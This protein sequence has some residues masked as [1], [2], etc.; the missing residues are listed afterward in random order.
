MALVLTLLVL[1]LLVTAVLEFDRSTRTMVKAAGNFRDG[2]KAFH[3]ATSGI[4]AAQALLKDD[5][6]R[7]G[8]RD[9]LTELW[10]TPLPPYPLGDGTVAAWIQDEGGKINVNMLV[11]P[12]GTK[13]SVP[14]QIEQ[15]KRLFRLKGLDPAP[16]DAIVDWLDRDEIE[17][18][19]GAESAYY[20]R[21][22]RPY[23]CRNGRMDTLAELHLVK[24]I[25]DEVYRTISPYLTV[26][27]SDESINVNTADPVVL[28]TLPVPGQDGAVA[29]P[30]DDKQ[31]ETIVDARPF[32]AKGDLIKVPGMT[33]AVVSQ[34]LP[35]ITVASSW[36]SVYAEG[37][38]NG[39]KKG[40]LAVVDRS[41]G[42][43][44][45]RYWRLAD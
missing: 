26:Y 32:A 28:Q 18:P 35:R 16:V 15:L 29:F 44:T 25:S 39:V 37:E 43:P 11:T 9:D 41:R 45:L 21:L 31:V 5:L 30:L 34:L 6:V 12:S 7:H 36:F 3:L 38:A 24:G 2:M 14:L 40:V 4:A 13:P 17:E 22:D 33:S 42:E 23:R 1:V 19:S 20:E 8:G 27:T 10:A